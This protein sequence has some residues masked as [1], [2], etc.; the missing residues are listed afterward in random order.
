MFTKSKNILSIFGFIIFIIII[1][2]AVKKPG[3]APFSGRYRSQMEQTEQA[4]FQSYQVLETMRNDGKYIRRV[5]FPETKQIT[6][7]FE[8]SDKTFTTIAGDT[9]EWYDNGILW[10]EGKYI[11]GNMEGIW[12]TYNY[13]NGK[14]QSECNYIKGKVEGACL[15]FDT[16]GHISS[17]SI[18][19]NGELDKIISF[20]TLGKVIFT[21]LDSL[22][23]GMK[24]IEKP[25]FPGGEKGLLSYISINIQYPS[26][27]REFGVE[28]GAIVKFLVSKDGSIKDVIVLRGLCEDIQKHITQ[29]VSDM[30]A[31]KPGINNGKAVNVT[32]T[33][34]IRFK[35]E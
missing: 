16:K 22:N 26:L 31:W 33:L 3:K 20:D 13:E 5:F 23:K 11:K 34:P 14:L 29:L 21:G 2:C 6:Q 28:G 32:Y 19:V 25:S 7:Y 12:K 27:A 15:N 17:K 35:L 18:F 4:L 30:P 10:K 24:L 1:S 9:K 8:Y